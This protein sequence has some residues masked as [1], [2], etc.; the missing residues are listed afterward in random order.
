MSTALSAPHLQQLVEGSGIHPD[1]VQRMGCSTATTPAQLAALHFKDYQRRVPALVLP[2]HDVHGTVAVHQIRPDIPRKNKRG[3]VLKYDTPEGQKL[4]LDVAPEQRPLLAQADVPLLVVEGLK[5]KWSVDSRVAPGQPLCTLGVIGTWGW[6][7]DKHPLP[8]WQAITLTDRQVIIVY[9]SDA[10]TVKEVGQARQ[11]LAQFLHQAGA[12][13]SH[14]DLPALPGAKCGADDYFVQG[15]SLE[16]LLAL[17]QETF[18]QPQ[19]IFIEASEVQEQEVCWLWA[20]YVARKK[21]HALDGDP[22][23]GKTLF[24]LQLASCVSRGHPMPDQLG[25]P[26]TPTGPP[27]RVLLIGMED[28]IEDTVIKRLKRAGADLTHIT[29]VNEMDDHGR[30]RPFLLSDLP[31][32]QQ[33]MEAKRPALVYIDSIQ[34][35]LG[36]NVDINRANQVTEILLPLRKFAEQYNAAIIF[37]RHPAKPG[38]SVAKLIHRGMG[39][40]AF[41]GS[42]R[43]GLFIEEHPCDPTKVLLVQ[44]K[45]NAGDM[46]RTQIFSKHG[47]HFEW[48]GV[49][50]INKDMMAGA[51]KGPSPQAFLE[52]CLWLETRLGDGRAYAATDLQEE[53]KQEGL[54]HGTSFAAKK[55]LGVVHTKTPAGTFVWHLPPLPPLSTP[56]TSTT[57]TTSTTSSTSSTSYSCDNSIPYTEAF[58]DEGPGEAAAPPSVEVV[59]VDDVDDVYDVDGVVTGHGGDALSP[60]YLD[61]VNPVNSVNPINPINPINSLVED[62]PLAQECMPGLQRVYRAPE[63]CKPAQPIDN[64]HDRGENAARVYGFTGFT[65]VAAN[66]ADPCL[67]EHVNALGTCDDCGGPWQERRGPDGVS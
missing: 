28:G 62:E 44:S 26:T 55:A 21:L 7:R 38:Q 48:C 39:S 32:L 56:S 27:A 45:S 66:G 14:V 16:D 5:K 1:V 46:G 2:V 11:A 47:G 18:P 31:A 35:V 22:G 24:A 40:Q 50:R 10:L 49:T 20:P 33:H 58:P 61:T 8:D 15:H 65:G 53:M 23:I 51:G 4:A 41:I 36:G 30:P 59:E 60:T 9:D 29:I 13:V 52:T 54:A 19:P 67:H 12:H 34:A 3:K 64:T 42:A 6:Q 57:S 17:A 43:L 37:T 63:R 25:T